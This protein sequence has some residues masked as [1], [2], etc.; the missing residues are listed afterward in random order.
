[1]AWSP[2][3]RA[4]SAALNCV[5]REWDASDLRDTLPPQNGPVCDVQYT[6]AKVLLVGDTN[7]GK[8]G[9][10]QRLATG[11]WMPSD[12]STV[13][14]WSTQW[15]LNL[16]STEPGVEREIWLWDFGGQADQRLIHQLYMDRV[17]LILLL[18][19][20]DKED[21][22]PGLRD[23]Q[24]A[25]RRCVRIETPHILVAGRI[26]SGFKASRPKINA[27]A[28][29]HRFAYHET[30][31][32][33]GEGC[34]QLRADLIAAISWGQIHTTPH[35][36]KLLRDEILKLRMEGEVLL[37]FKELRELLRQRLPQEERFS[38]E[39]L[40][41][42]ISLLDGPGA[43]KELA[44]G[45]YILLAPEWISVYGQAVIRTLRSADNDLGTLPIRTIADGNLIYQS[46][47]RDGR[48]V[49]VKR[50]PPPEERI[51]LGEMEQ[52]LEKRGLCLRQGDKLVFP[53]HCGRDRPEV[54]DHPAVLVSYTVRGFLDDIYATLVVQLADS[55]AFQLEQLWRDAAD[56]VTLVDD[57]HMGIKLS[58]ESGSAGEISVYFG[59]G[60]TETEQVIFANY[61]HAHL[62]DKSEKAQRLRHYVCPECHTPKGNPQVLME[63]LLAKKTKADTECDKCGH[64]F[65]LWDRLEQ[66]FA[67]DDVRI[68]VEELQAKDVVRLNSRRKG[69]LLVLDVGAR[70][71]SANQKW[72]EVPQDEDDGID[73][74][75]EFTDE[76][77]NGVGKGL[78]LQ[79]KAGNAHLIKRKSDGAEIFRIKKPRWV[80]TWKCQPYPVMLV[81]GTFKTD[82]SRTKGNEKLEFA[83][84]RWMEITSELD[85]LS[86]GGK[87]PVKQFVF[88]GERLDMASV[89]QWRER[90]LSQAQ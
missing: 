9:L 55:Q 64:R 24:M 15:S 80:N 19:N 86:E 66:R 67:S 89:R 40:Q 4:F 84:I 56:F 87:T 13:G 26:D 70:I 81:I 23:W 68:K 3:G 46:V 90:I 29:E 82:N 37:T 18:F 52:Q 43:V 34:S 12:G 76:D 49:E 27:F 48:Q 1:V 31:A 20:A 39:V 41:T 30:S 72:Y 22:L 65:L 75:M 33:T 36:F 63:K 50:L 44:Y 79:L 38:D 53:S 47:G 14:A 6:N 88:K 35:I 8:T 60:I 85:R 28:T 73:I 5:W 61:I 78:C 16:P 11:E 59:L 10:T 45:T 7:S 2:D 74:V 51:V 77:G 62:E 32:L 25:L 54:A 17:A 42:V 58:R 71:T 83:D 21:V 57:H 69:K